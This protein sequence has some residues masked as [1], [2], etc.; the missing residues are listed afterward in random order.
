MKKY[1]LIIILSSLSYINIYSQNLNKDSVIN[2]LKSDEL[3]GNVK[4][5]IFKTFEFKE[6]DKEIGKGNLEN[7]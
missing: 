7:F 6:I 1:L 3:R 2:D 4:S 5:V